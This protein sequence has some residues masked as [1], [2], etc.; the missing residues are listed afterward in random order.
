MFAPTLETKNDRQMGTDLA[1]K[2][3]AGFENELGLRPSYATAR[4]GVAVL[5][6]RP[7]TGQG[8][9]PSDLFIFPSIFPASLGS[10]ALRVNLAW[11][12][13]SQRIDR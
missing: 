12:F 9:N 13:V 8:P 4:G 7:F 2:N 1:Q 11:G 6:V 5:S 10:M 3:E